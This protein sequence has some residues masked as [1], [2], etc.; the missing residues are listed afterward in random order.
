M[1][2]LGTIILVALFIIGLLAF[3]AY[4]IYVTFIKVQLDI[5][6]ELLYT[7]QVA[8]RDCYNIKD[9]ISLRYKFRKSYSTF[10]EDKIIKKFLSNSYKTQAEVLLATMDERIRLIELSCFPS[11]KNNKDD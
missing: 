8:I 11:I 4:Y 5:A 2:T 6:R 9:M 10:V 7:Y 3:I 1:S